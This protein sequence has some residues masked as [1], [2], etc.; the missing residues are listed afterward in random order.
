MQ[1]TE[2]LGGSG[3]PG[4]PSYAH[5]DNDD[6]TCATANDPT[7]VQCLK[8]CEKGELSVSPK[9][10]LAAW[11]TWSTLFYCELLKTA[12][13][14]TGDPNGLEAPVCHTAAGTIHVPDYSAATRLIVMFQRL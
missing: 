13:Y 10:E 14:C 5:P 7:L 11:K 8:M 6:A 2:S 9:C 4:K 12:S 3:G 1:N